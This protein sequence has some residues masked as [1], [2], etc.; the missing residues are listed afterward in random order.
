MTSSY[1]KEVVDVQWHWMT[2]LC[3]EKAAACPHFKFQHI[4]LQLELAVLIYVRAI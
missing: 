1:S 3:T 4:I 2:G